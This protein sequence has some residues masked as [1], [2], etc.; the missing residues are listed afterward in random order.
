M[1]LNAVSVLV[2]VIRDENR[3]VQ[4]PILGIEVAQSKKDIC[5]SQRKYIQDLLSEVRLLEYKPANTSIVQ[6]PKVREYPE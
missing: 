6:N 3:L 1:D 2:I 4:G 5:L